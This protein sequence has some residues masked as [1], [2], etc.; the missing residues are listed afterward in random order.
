MIRSMQY[1]HSTRL[2]TAGNPTL[3][4]EFPLILLLE[5]EVETDSS[6]PGSCQASHH[7]TGPRYQ[8]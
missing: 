7:H 6:Q 8:T 3:S 4:P 2:S 1:H 5:K